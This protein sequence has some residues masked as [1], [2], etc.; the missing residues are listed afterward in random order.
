MNA[1]L[2]NSVGDLFPGLAVVAGLVEIRFVVVPLVH[3]GRDVGRGRI[4]GR[5][6]DR[7]DL[8]PLRHQALWRCHV[9]PVL[10]AIARHVNQTIVGAGPNHTL[11]QRR[12]HHRK[13]RAVV[14]D[15]G[16]V[17]GDW[18]ARWSLLRLVVARQIGTDNLPALSFIDRFEK[19][20]ASGV[21]RVGI[22]RRKENG[23]VPLKPV[24]Q[25]VRAGAHRIIRIR[26]DVA[27]LLRF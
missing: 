17:F 23:K 16:V 21:K 24:L 18:A 14:L 26:R 9:V 4:V 8:N 6:I 13:D 12:F 27:Q 10:A 19:H 5:S 2:G 22:V 20:V 11:L 1:L 3:R 25:N 15:A 7:I